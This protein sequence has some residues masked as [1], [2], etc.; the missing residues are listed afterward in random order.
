MITNKGLNSIC[1]KKLSEI[2]DLDCYRIR[3]SPYDDFIELNR[4]EIQLELSKYGKFFDFGT[5]QLKNIENYV[6]I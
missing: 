1:N 5:K 2:N 4:D 3:N 6:D